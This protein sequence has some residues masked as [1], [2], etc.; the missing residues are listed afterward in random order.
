M[1]YKIRS[2][3][4]VDSGG[5]GVTGWAD[6]YVPVCGGTT[7]TG[8]LQ[9][10]P[11]TNQQQMGWPL[12]SNGTGVLPSY[13]S[14]GYTATSAFMASVGGD[15]NNV[16]GDGTPYVVD[17]TSISQNVGSDFTGNNLYTA[18]TTGLYYFSVELASTGPYVG[19]TNIQ[20][21]LQSSGTGTVLMSTRGAISQGS[22]AINQ[23]FGAILY[24]EATHTVSVLFTVSGSTKTASI[25]GG[26][27]T[28]FAA[29]F[30]G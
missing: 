16:T 7:A 9:T 1:A 10:I 14:Y 2:P 28:R 23:A 21:E 18:P 25:P 19:T 24:L 8:A 12:R 3:L 30:L 15:Q 13:Q 5:T 27:S 20:I 6:S 11:T 26:S 29:I 4:A 22:A 17:F